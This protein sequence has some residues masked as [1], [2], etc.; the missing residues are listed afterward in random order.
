[1]QRP[2]CHRRAELGWKLVCVVQ[3]LATSTSQLPAV[4][5]GPQGPAAHTSR[6]RAASPRHSIPY[7]GRDQENIPVLPLFICFSL[8][9]GKGL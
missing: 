2:A 8:R 5:P 9:G 7:G 3:T 6:A 4:L 1:M